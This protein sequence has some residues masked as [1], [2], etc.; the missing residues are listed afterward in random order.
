[1]RALEGGDGGET[2]AVTLALINC[3]TL[4]TDSLTERL[5]IRNRLDG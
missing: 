3:I 1:V 2:K 4:R 5:A